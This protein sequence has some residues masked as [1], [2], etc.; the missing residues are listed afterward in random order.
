MC[1]FA[2]LSPITAPSCSGWARLLHSSPHSKGPDI[3]T[4]LSHLF[5]KYWL[6]PLMELSLGSLPSRTALLEPFEVMRSG[7]SS[8]LPS[9]YNDWWG[10]RES[11][12]Q[13]VL[14]WYS[15]QA[16]AYN[17]ALKTYLSD[18]MVI[19][20]CRKHQPRQPVI[21][22]DRQ[23]HGLLPQK[24]QPEHHQQKRERGEEDQFEDTF[25]GKGVFNA[26]HRN[27]HSSDVGC[28]TTPG[29]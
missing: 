21:E 20:L 17:Q 11:Y 2:C 19:M 12:S 18:P 26:T 5:E 27:G 9:D 16:D 22:Q 10:L 3:L 23:H 8:Q 1:K 14:Q 6:T 25:E 4:V 24:Q 13:Q 15:K 29:V 7:P 28:A